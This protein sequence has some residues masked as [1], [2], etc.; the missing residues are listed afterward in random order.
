MLNR[1]LL[2]LDID[3]APDWMVTEAADLLVRAGVR[4]TWFVTHRSPVLT[5]LLSEPLFE[6][7]VHPNF[8]PGSSHGSEPAS[9]MQHVLD[10]V[11]GARTVRTHSLFQSERHSQ[12]MAEDFGIRTDC[13]LLLMDSAHVAPH[14]VRF[15][16]Q[17]PWLTR[18][19][20]VFQDNM[21]MF[22][23]RRWSLDHSAFSSPGLKVFDFHP[24]HLALNAHAFDVYEQLRCTG[25]PLADVT[26]ADVQAL[27]NPGAG[28]A[29][30]FRS[31]IDR[32]RDGSF[33]I[34]QYVDLW[35]AES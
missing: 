35:E 22:S 29:T 1:F 31:L 21:F 27:R 33:T 11:P 34:D 26:R 17:G 28:A 18:V 30:L 23:G 15:S 12:M 9:V 7:G 16:S 8:L 10:M 13:S 5:E 4:A 32:M 19:P 2:T 14:R 3:W 24:V 25:K 6:V 20:H